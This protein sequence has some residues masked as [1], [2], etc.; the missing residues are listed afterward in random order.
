MFALWHKISLL[1]ALLYKCIHLEVDIG[2]E[3]FI[4]LDVELCSFA[5]S[6]YLFV[7][8]FAFV[9]ASFFVSMTYFYS[10]LTKALIIRPP[11]CI[12]LWFFTAWDNFLFE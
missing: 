11:E 3:Y 1:S 6:L 8:R 9:P 12:L 4:L 10:H 2:V 5:L 7:C